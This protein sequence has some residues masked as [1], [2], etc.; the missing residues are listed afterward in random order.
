MPNFITID[1]LASKL[2][3]KYP[4]TWNNFPKVSVFKE[5]GNRF[6]KIIFDFNDP[7]ETDVDEIVSFQVLMSC[8]EDIFSVRELMRMGEIVVNDFS[9]IINNLYRKSL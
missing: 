8:G 2:Y 5:E 6:G 7:G 4:A 1:E 3:R 9:D